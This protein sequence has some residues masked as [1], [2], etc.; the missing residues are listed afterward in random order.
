MN[1]RLERDELGYPNSLKEF[2]RDLDCIYFRGNLQLLQSRCVAV[3]GCR[4]CTTYG[5]V[6]AKAIGKKLAE[7]GVT[8]VSGLAAG[9][10]T[11]SHEGALAAGGNTIAVLGSGTDVY[12][13]PRNKNLQESI[14]EKGLLVSEYP[15]ETAAKSFHFPQRNRIISGLAESIIVV[16][17]GNRSGALITAECAVEQGKEVYAVPGNI[18]SFQSFGT[19]KLIRENVKPLI[20]LDD[21]LVDM[22]IEP[23]IMEDTFDRLGE[24]EKKV[25]NVIQN[26]GETTIDAIYH[27]T[28]IKPSVINGIITV[29]EMKGIVFSSM[30]K[31]FVAKF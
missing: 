10:D 26:C 24:E 5:K 17:A 28:N 13:P 2:V 22:G 30:G 23:Y 11:A 20:L 31:I 12:Y 14:G 7:N 9:I 15:P 3:V 8:V 16:E 19:N 21:I 6:V 25:L 27:K 1:G 29:L 18:T 4:D